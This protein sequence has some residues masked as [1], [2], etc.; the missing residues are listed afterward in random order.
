VKIMSLLQIWVLE[1]NNADAFLIE[2]ALRRT[3]VA[4]EKTVIADGE[5]AIGMIRSCQSGKT[6]APHIIL[7]DLHL[8]KRDGVEIVN[9]MR[10]TR[11]FDGVAIAVLSSSPPKD[12]EMS[13]LG[14]RR[15]L[16]KPPN[17]EDFLNEVSKAVI[18]MAPK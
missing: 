9:A 14:I 2:L 11:H 10:E 16:Q 3:G 18:E 13:R 7:M 6:S 12:G 8:P 4:F 15:H 1:D 5:K 17:L